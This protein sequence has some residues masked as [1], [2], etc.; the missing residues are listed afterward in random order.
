[1]K[2]DP[3]LPLAR[4]KAMKSRGY[5]SDLILI[6]YFERC[7]AEVPD[8]TAI[9]GFNSMSQ[10]ENP[11]GQKTHLQRPAHLRC[12]PMVI[13]QKPAQ[14]LAALHRPTTVDFGV[15]GKQQNVALPLV[16][17]LSMV[18]LDIFAHSPPQGVLA[19]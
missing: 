6:D 4:V 14:P 18:M 16:I 7:L 5:W 1:M 8:K 9:V 10:A 15:E 12:L 3:I 11:Y 19:K 2:F 17:A 13:T